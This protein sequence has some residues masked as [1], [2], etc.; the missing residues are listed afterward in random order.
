MCTLERETSTSS[1]K[2]LHPPNSHANGNVEISQL[3]NRSHLMLLKYKG[4]KIKKRL[5]FTDRGQMGQGLRHVA[6]KY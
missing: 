4:L 2:A 1:L 3:Q 5:L 6:H